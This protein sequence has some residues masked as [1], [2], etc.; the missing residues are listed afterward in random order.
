MS[1][2]ILMAEEFRMTLASEYKAKR[3]EESRCKYET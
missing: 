3:N 1:T 2:V